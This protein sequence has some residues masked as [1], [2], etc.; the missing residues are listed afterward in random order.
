MKQDK[1]QQRKQLP[2]KSRVTNPKRG[3]N[4]NENYGT[5]ERP[6]HPKGADRM[7][8]DFA[9]P[10]ADQDIIREASQPADTSRKRKGPGR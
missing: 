2:E 9:N 3:T 1:N 4:T 10:G 8:E 5:K 6:S 7:N